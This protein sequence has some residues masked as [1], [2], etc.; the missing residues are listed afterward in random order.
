MK[1]FSVQFCNIAYP[2]FIKLETQDGQKNLFSRKQNPLSERE[3]SYRISVVLFFR[4]RNYSE[5]IFARTFATSIV[6]TRF[7]G[8]TYTNSN[9]TIIS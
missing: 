8:H 4:T 1:Y 2:A 9:P 3:N 7:V 6:F 5:V